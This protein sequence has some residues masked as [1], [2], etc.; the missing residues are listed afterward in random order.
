MTP[1]GELK[2]ATLELLKRSGLFWERM[3]SGKVKVKGGFMNLCKEGTA[4]FVIFPQGCVLWI[5][6]KPKGQKTSKDRAEKQAAFAEK[7]KALGHL[8]V[9][10][11]SIEDVKQALEDV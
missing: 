5:E 1:E 6:L 3:Q 8:H 2:A 10:A 7:V 11:E 9:K 4:D